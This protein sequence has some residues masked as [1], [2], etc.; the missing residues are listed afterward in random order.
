MTNKNGLLIIISSPSGGGKTTVIEGLKKHSKFKFEYSISATT[1][2]P[3]SGE[4]NGS[5]YYFLSEA[6]FRAKIE[7]GEFLE[8][9]QVHQYLYGTPKSYIDNCLALG[10]KIILDV[11]V[12][13]G[14]N[15]KKMYPTNSITIF[16]EP[17]SLEI[18]INRLKNRKTDSRLEIEKRLQRV[19]LEL[20]KK[21]QYD[22]VV[23]NE[24]IENTIQ[25][26]MII[27]ENFK[28]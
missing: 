22:F 8:W 11:D 25:K 26:V 7:R 23:V 18:L 12:N 14:L 15:I 21:N 13:G 16:I 17:P 27:I 3:R 4:V 10:K 2:E 1:R 20:A 24:Q 9:E 6:E 19:P 5:D 28:Y